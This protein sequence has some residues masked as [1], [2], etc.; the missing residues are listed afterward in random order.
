MLTLSFGRRKDGESLSLVHL[1]VG[2]VRLEQNETVRQHGYDVSDYK[3]AILGGYWLMFAR[4]SD[5][6]DLGTV[7]L[8]QKGLPLMNEARSHGAES[9]N[10]WCSC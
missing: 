8:V 9:L 4:S 10:I 7:L 1:S 2:V 5:S 6:F 3:D